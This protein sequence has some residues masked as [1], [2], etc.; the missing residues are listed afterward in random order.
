MW[1]SACL[2]MLVMFACYAMQVKH[3]PYMSPSEHSDVLADHETKAKVAGSIHNVL[4]G[5]LAAVSNRMKKKARAVNQW[6][7][8]QRRKAD[9]AARER[10]SAFF[11]NYNTVEATLLASAVLV[12]LAG[13]MFESN[14]LSSDYYQEQRDIITYAVVVIIASSVSYFLVV[15]LSEVYITTCSKPS[16]SKRS[17]K[18][19]SSQAAPR[20]MQASAHRRYRSG[21]ARPG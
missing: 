5:N 7:T 15:F 14:R 20:R 13:V 4:A 11:F 21:R 19:R 1:A 2:L 6:G 3:T 8:A 18:G 10:A 16:S 17:P 12:N 9:Q